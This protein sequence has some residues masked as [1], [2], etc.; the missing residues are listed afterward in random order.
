VVLPPGDTE[1]KLNAPAPTQA[2]S[3]QRCQQPIVNSKGLKS[4][5]LAQTLRFR[6]VTDK[7]KIIERFHHHPG[8]EAAAR[9]VNVDHLYHF[10]TSLSFSDS[11][12]SFAAMLGAPKIFWKRHPRQNLSTRPCQIYP[13]NRS[14]GNLN[15]VVWHVRNPVGKTF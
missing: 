6:N 1:T 3:I 2:K 7:Q 5:S 8:D 15:S 14:Q 11:V 10:Y 13:Q 12:Y 9:H 4:V